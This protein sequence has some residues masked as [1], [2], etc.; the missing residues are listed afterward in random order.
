[1]KQNLKIILINHTFQINYF[2]RRWELF[3]QE[4][5]DVDVTLLAPAEFQ[6]YGKGYSFGKTNILQGKELDRGN[7]HKR[8]FRVKQHNPW[9]WTSPD[10]KRLFRTINPDIVYYL[11]FHT[12]LSLLQVIKVTKRYVPH[13]KMIAFSMRGPYHNLVLD[14]NGLSPIKKIRRYV[15]YR[16]S[17]YVLK[18]VINEC[19]AIFCHYPDALDCFRKEGYKGPIYMQTQVGVNTEWFHENYE[20]RKEIREKYKLGNSFV[21][22]SATRF[23]PDKGLLD[24]IA[25]LPQDGD[26]KFLMMGAGTEDEEIAI[27]EA[28]Q[29]RDLQD[30]II[31]T[32][33]VDWY[34]M[35]KY[36][37]AVD[38]AIHVPRTTK[39]WV[40]TFSLAVVQ[41][42]ATKKP[43]IGNTSGSV[44]YQVGFQEM[45][46][47]EGDIYALNQKIQWVLNNKEEA[48]KIA[49]KM[50]ERTIRS[51]SVEHL[52]MLFYNTIVDI[53]NGRYDENKVDM[54]N[55]NSF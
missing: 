19:D 33:F 39:T 54:T 3:A 13:A 2:S 6:W 35:I 47:P 52:N 31:L 40:E 22:G 38:C 44:P 49:H 12:Q 23:T 29:K 51:F 26:W 43:V 21:F 18:T 17:K 53:Y 9:G 28:I 20:F 1:M 32:G 36:W 41:P 5:P 48:E 4:H 34:D 25:A 46:V 10:F 11:G 27:R 15:S 7:F 55:G 8:L 45:I 50:Y 14:L 30:K 42:M 16:F 24:I 37:N